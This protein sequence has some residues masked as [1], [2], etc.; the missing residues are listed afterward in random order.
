[1][2]YNYLKHG[3][4]HYHEGKWYKA[5]VKTVEKMIVD[6][7]NDTVTDLTKKF[8]VFDTNNDD[9]ISI[10]M[11]E[12]IDESDSDSWQTMD[13][14][15][16]K[17]F[18][19]NTIPE[20]ADKELVLFK[21]SNSYRPAIIRTTFNRK[22]VD[23]KLT[24]I[25]DKKQS[26]TINVT[27]QNFTTINARFPKYSI[28]TKVQLKNKIYGIKN[29][30]YKYYVSDNDRDDKY[31]LEESDISPGFY[32]DGDLIDNSE[33][34]VHLEDLRKKR[35]YVEYLKQFTTEKIGNFV[36]IEDQWGLRKTGDIPSLLRD[37]TKPMFKDSYYYNIWNYE[38][39]EFHQKHGAV[40]LSDVGTFSLKFTPPQFFI[41]IYSSF[42]IN[43][44]TKNEICIL[45]VHVF[46]TLE[47][48]NSKTFLVSELDLKK[49]M[50]EEAK[51]IKYYEDDNSWDIIE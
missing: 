3:F 20:L 27:P 29:Y 8:V 26:R 13:G 36:L 4:F 44:I 39:I 1:M 25:D 14:I 22:L 38:S 24:Y 23:I 17:D 10:K 11:W 30:F 16:T 46:Y 15:I 34:E 42:N 35:E 49:Q 6:T 28:G 2:S 18:D 51:V 7:E 12:M 50:N 21:D 41:P 43:K 19:E 48:K 37:T 5:S 40:M 9:D 32:W 45:D 31:Y 33:D 47:D